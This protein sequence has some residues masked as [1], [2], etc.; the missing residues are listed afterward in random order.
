MNRNKN[1]KD[2]ETEII[3]ENASAKPV[4]KL[5]D[6]GSGKHSEGKALKWILIGLGA[7]CL[8]MVIF[9]LL[10]HDSGSKFVRYV[11]DYGYSVEYDESR[12]VRDLVRLDEKPTYM[13]RIGFKENPYMN[14]LSVLVYEDKTENINDVIAAFQPD[15]DL[16]V[17]EKSTFGAGNYAAM[18]LY[19]TDKSGDEPVDVEYFYN[20]ERGVIVTVSYDKAHKSE[21]ERMLASLKFNEW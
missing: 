17:Q 8:L 19:Y 21:V 4:E 2:N 13:V 6:S 16:G 14:F 7:A 9:L 11:S 15:Y 20:A 5:A 1:L 18:R 12:Y 3:E 10:L